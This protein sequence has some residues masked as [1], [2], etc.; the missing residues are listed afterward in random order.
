MTQFITQ[1]IHIVIQSLT[2][3]ISIMIITDMITMENMDIMVNITVT[4]ESTVTKAHLMFTHIH[5]MVN[6]TVTIMRA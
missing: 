6:G 2:T 1:Q 3:H 4:T 5:M